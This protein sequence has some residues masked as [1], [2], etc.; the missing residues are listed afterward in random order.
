MQQ[1]KAQL[2]WET[3][4]EDRGDMTTTVEKGQH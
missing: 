1:I 4:S 2:L 3:S